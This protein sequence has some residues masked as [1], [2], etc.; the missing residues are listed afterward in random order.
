M[1][2]SSAEARRAWPDKVICINFPSAGHLGTEAQVA[3]E[4]RRLLA[5]IA[6]GD[7]FAVGITENIPDDCWQRSLKAI[8]RILRE[9]GHVPY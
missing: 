9:E 7:R 1:C 3:S 4:M 2:W 5:A 6:P 8:S